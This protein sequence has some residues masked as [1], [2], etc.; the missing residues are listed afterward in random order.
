LL[1][2]IG[3]HISGATETA[4][5]T[6]WSGYIAT[7]SDFTA[8]SAQW[9]V[10]TVQ[11]SEASQFSSTWIGIDG[12]TNTSLIQAGTE[13]DAS[14]GATTYY[15]WYELLPALSIPVEYVSPGD[16]MKVSIVENSPGTWAIVIAD[17]TSEQT[18]SGSVAYNTPQT[19][20]EWIEEAPSS[21]SL[22]RFLFDRL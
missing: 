6:N 8:V 2:T 19:S 14:D 7:G 9:V 11:P 13:Q 18:V 5:S 3:P 20:A 1:P 17:L 22:K 10:P 15:A 12:A 4:E 16:V 21:A